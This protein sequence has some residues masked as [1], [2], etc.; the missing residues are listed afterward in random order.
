M[1][2]EFC[3]RAPPR[4]DAIFKEA[5][6]IKSAIFLFENT[7]NEFEKV[8]DLDKFT[9]GRIELSL[10]PLNFSIDAAI[11]YTDAAIGKEGTALAV[12]VRDYRGNLVYLASKLMQV[13]TPYQ[14]E[15]KA[16][17]GATKLIEQKN[18]LKAFW[19]CDS[20]TVVNEIKDSSE[21]S[22]WFVYN[23]V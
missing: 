15:A 17:A 8:A 11:I 20:Q 10:T 18:I 14:A 1:L 2:N 16:L 3:V 22:S 12:V 19:F 23:D 7:V 4:N 6:D 5:K 13:M 9:E 21:P